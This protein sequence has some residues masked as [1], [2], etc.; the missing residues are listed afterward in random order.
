VTS[1]TNS[2]GRPFFLTA[3][4]TSAALFQF[5][6][7]GLPRDLVQRSALKIR[8]MLTI[9]KDCAGKDFLS[10]RRHVE[11]LDITLFVA[12]LFR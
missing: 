8:F 6:L 10:A 3:G 12:R 4:K 7:N 1:H 9:F 11:Q 2:T 5:V